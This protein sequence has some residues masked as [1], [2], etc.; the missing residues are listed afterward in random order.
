MRTAL[1]KVQCIGLSLWFGALHGARR[2]PPALFDT[3]RR[4]L[5]R[6]G[7]RAFHGP[8]P[9]VALGVLEGERS[10]DYIDVLDSRRNSECQPRGRWVAATTRTRRL[11][12][13][14]TRAVAPIRRRTP[15]GRELLA[16]VCAPLRRSGIDLRCHPPGAA[17]G[18]RCVHPGRRARAAALVRRLAPCSG[19]Q[20]NSVTRRTINERHRQRVRPHISQQTA[21]HCLDCHKSK[22]TT[23]FLKG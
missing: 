10:P 11:R 6:D 5:W 19:T 20:T 9:D 12:L 2:R 22:Q 14:A 15:M 3:A 8:S 13:R 16:R 23:S 21:K 1:A 17:A 18:A 7:R 4:E